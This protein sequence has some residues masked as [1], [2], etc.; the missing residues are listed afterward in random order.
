MTVVLGAR[1]KRG[2]AENGRPAAGRGMQDF[3][4]GEVTEWPKVIAC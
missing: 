1:A 3:G 2:A 4:P